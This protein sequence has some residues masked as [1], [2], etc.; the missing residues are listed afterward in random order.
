MS[1]ASPKFYTAAE[2]A[3]RLKLT[4]SRVRQFCRERR[5]GTLKAGVWFILEDELRRFVKRKRLP[6]RPPRIEK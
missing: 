6:G 2:A 5:F 3:K 4:E 1:T